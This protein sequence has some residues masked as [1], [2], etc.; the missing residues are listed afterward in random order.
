MCVFFCFL[1]KNVHVNKIFNYFCG[2]IKNNF[3]NVF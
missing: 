3:E 2:E 1:Y